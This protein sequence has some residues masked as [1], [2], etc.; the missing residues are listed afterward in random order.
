MKTKPD[1]FHRMAEAIVT[2]GINYVFATTL[3]PQERA[4][5]AINTKTDCQHQISQMADILRAGGSD[6]ELR[7]DFIHHLWVLDRQDLYTD[8]DLYPGF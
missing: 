8:G 5:Q 1:A 4:L 7:K 3:D 2:D 6:Y